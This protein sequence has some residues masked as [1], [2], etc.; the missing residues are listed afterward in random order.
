[1][2]TNRA[3]YVFRYDR[4]D[5]HAVTDN[6]SGSTLPPQN[7]AGMWR[8]GARGKFPQGA[9]DIDAAIREIGEI[10]HHL[11]E[12]HPQTK[13]VSSEAAPLAP[14]ERLPEGPLQGIEVISYDGGTGTLTICI[15]GP[16]LRRAASN[17]VLAKKI[18]AALT[19]Y[20]D[21]NAIAVEVR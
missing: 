16:L 11:F 13:I 14:G 2:T 4:S 10:G 20:C 8:T 9:F 1:M 7:I 15:D 12:F 18:I 5:L 3:L 19:E 21:V 17:E 6:P